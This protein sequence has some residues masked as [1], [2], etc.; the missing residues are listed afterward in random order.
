MAAQ[1]LEP[2]SITNLPVGMNFILGGYGFARVNTLLDPSFPI[3]EIDSR[4]H[5]VAGA[6]ARSINFFG[7]SSKIDVILPYIAGNY[8][9]EYLGR[10][11]GISRSGFGDLRMRFS[12]NFVGSKAMDVLDYQ[13]YSPGF[14]SGISIQ[15]IAPTGFYEG[16]YLIN[17]GANRWVVKPQ[18]GGAKSCK[19]WTFEAYVGL[20]L[21][22]E[23]NDFLEGNSLE[24][25][26]LYTFKGHVIRSL[27]NSKWMS[28][29]AGYA[30][31]GNTKVNGSLRETQISTLRLA[32][33]YA[34]PISKT[35]SIKISAV[36]GIRYEKG[37]DYNGLSVLYQHSWLDKRQIQKLKPK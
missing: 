19:N 16:E 20:W 6:Y 13:K 28:L 14:V 8:E 9:G 36:S 23:N 31:G 17:I 3:Q 2:R 15:V 27:K 22:G 35:S 37:S 18:W 10:E 24:Q 25:Q 12:F 21:F 26:P 32:F 34:L 7:L 11:I 30:V 4:L 5:S 29:S 33:M 1:E